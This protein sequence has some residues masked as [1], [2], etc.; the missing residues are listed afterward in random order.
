MSEKHIGWDTASGPDRTTQAFVC[1]LCDAAGQIDY[2]P[3]H[4]YFKY[5]VETE[6]EHTHWFASS[7]DGPWTQIGGT[8]A[9]V[10][11]AMQARFHR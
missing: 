11:V 7:I 5:G 8:F 9:N 6:R 2:K 3:Q 4:R 10:G 1:D